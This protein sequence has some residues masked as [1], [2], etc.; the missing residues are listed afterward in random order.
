ML[1]PPG[2]RSLASYAMTHRAE[3]AIPFCSIDAPAEDRAP[4]PGERAIQ[5]QT[6]DRLRHTAQLR[7]L[8]R[9]P[10]PVRG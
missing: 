6:F 10:R 1:H 8:V 7:T 5:A 2:L 9:L 3:L 4:L